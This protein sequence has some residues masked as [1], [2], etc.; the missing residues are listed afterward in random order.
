[1]ALPLTGD[2]RSGA[3]IVLAV[4]V[5][6]VVGAV[7]VA[8]LGRGWGAGAY[9]RVLVGVR[10]VTL[11]AVAGLAVAGAPFGLLLAAA[12]VAGL[13]N[14]AAFGFLRSILNDV[15]EGGRIPRALGLASTLSET[16]F[17]GAPVL[18][19]V[20]GTI[21][22]VLAVVALAL[23]G[24]LP[25]VLVPG[26]ARAAVRAPAGP[27]AGLLRPEIVLWLGCTLAGSAVAAS[28]EVGAVSLALR[29]G[30]APGMGFVFTVA[31][32]VAAVAGGVW[33]SV[34]N[35]MPRRGVV[36]WYLAAMG[37]GAGLVAAGAAMWA[38]LLGAV[39]VGLVMA[40]LSTTYSLM[41]DGLAPAHRKAEVFALSRTANTLGVIVSSSTLSAASLGV[42]QAVAAGL[43]VLAWGA[44]F[45]TGRASRKK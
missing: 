10:T 28:I 27:H 32:C 29:Y 9:L 8:R 33:V 34:R 24:A 26:V 11:L 1:L 3:E 38:T 14:S 31:L 43:V 40:P 23:V 20:L 6:Q 37:L 41:L 44:V 18:A 39:L 22:P 4:T 16:V 2:A 13:V 12:G 35:R 7:P 21:D 30:M 15:V 25:V 5:A 45:V 36:L 17:V 19:S 42:T